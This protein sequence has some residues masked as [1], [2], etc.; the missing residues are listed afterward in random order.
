[1]KFTKREIEAIK[2]TE[3]RQTFFDD[4][5]PGLV[6]RVSPTGHKSF[7]YSYRLG[8]GRGFDKKWVHLGSFP[9]MTVEQARE[10]AKLMAASLQFGQDPAKQIQEDKE[11]LSM[12][13]AL[14]KFRDEH[15][16]KLKPQ[17]RQSYERL[18]EKLIFPCFGKM[19]AK[20]VTFADVAGFHARLR[21]TPYQANRAYAVLSKF[22]NWCEL[23]GYRE[24][25]TNPCEGITK[26]KEKKRQNFMGAHELGILG[27]TL[28]HMEMTWHERQKTK[29]K[30]TAPLVDTITPQAAAVI[31][32]LM[33]TGARVGEILSL[34]WANIYLEEGIAKLPDSKTGFKIL[35]LTHPA[36][37]V[38]KGIP[39][40]DR[41]VFPS[42]SECGH[43]VNIKDAWG[44]VLKQANL[45]GWRLHDLRH[46]FASAMVN[47]GAS[48]PIVGKILGHS[49]ASTTQRYAHLEENPARKAAEQA[50]SMIAHAIEDRKES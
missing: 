2:A 1:M 25:N 47:G 16:A 29:E 18:I 27:E 10:K 4:G 22:F 31:R 30:R 42:D 9:V 34:E 19:R 3:K 15:I 21:E 39:Q 33:F 11:A 37:V 50:A 28:S 6:L 7:Y 26:Y 40:V 35:Q 32:L 24:R 36:V 38:L 12:K 44:D 20:D 14:E 41:W 49:N 8:K 23:C 46:A 43:M 13:E 5:M 48:L 17:T 45:P